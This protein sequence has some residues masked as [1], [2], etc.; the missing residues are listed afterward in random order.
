M[1][2]PSLQMTTP[3]GTTLQMESFVSD[4]QTRGRNIFGEHFTLYSDDM[5]IIHKLLAY[6]LKDSQ[7]LSYFN[8]ASQKGLLLS[9][10]VGCG[11]TSL[12][13]L[14]RTILQP[15]Q[16][17]GIKSCR[18]IT[19]DFIRDGYEVIQRY[20]TFAYTSTGERQPITTCFDD[21]GA[22]STLKYYGNQCN[23]L[24]EILLSRYDHYI[25]ARMITHAT[26]N[27]SASELESYYGSR[28]RSRMREMFNLISFS[29]DSIDKRR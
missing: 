21:L 16:R 27:L 24:G 4:L 6:F 8:L 15:S 22:E 2:K 14:M 9:G 13:T 18:E 10:P 1:T 11:K 19:F 17:F 20:S 26:T 23:V 5:E 3:S 12:I 28:V 7:A 29:A 25:N